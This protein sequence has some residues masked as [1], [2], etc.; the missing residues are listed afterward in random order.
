MDYSDDAPATTIQLTARQAQA[1]QAAIRQWARAGL[2]S[3]SLAS[4]LQESIQTQEIFD[5]QK[6]AKYSFRLAV[7]CLAVAISSVVFDDYFRKLIKRI[8][9]LPALLRG[10]ITAA[11]ATAVHVWA[12]RRS[13]EFPEDVYLNEA[14]HALGALLFALAAFQFGQWLGL[15]EPTNSKGKKDENRALNQLLLALSVIY[16][17]VGLVA[18][19]NFIWSWGMYVLG[20]WF[21]AVTGYLSG[22]VS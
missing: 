4:K 12:Y 10:S 20:T 21:G 19:T 5:W 8:L 3:D 14:V 1:A 22:Y 9:E 11:G 15:G 16:L 18:K 17:S 13:L 2:L 7:L 6:F